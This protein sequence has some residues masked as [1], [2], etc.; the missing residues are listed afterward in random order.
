MNAAFACCCF[1]SLSTIC[2]C[3]FKWLPLKEI[4]Y[5]CCC[6]FFRIVIIMVVRWDTHTEK[7][8]HPSIKLINHSCFIDE[9]KNLINLIRL[10]WL[11]KEKKTHRSQ[12]KYIELSKF[13][14][15]FLPVDWEMWKN[16]W[17]TRLTMHVFVHS[18]SACVCRFAQIY[19]LRGRQIE[20]AK[21]NGKQLIHSS[22]I[23]IIS[24]CLM[25]GFLLEDLRFFCTIFNW[26]FLESSKLN[27]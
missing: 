10:C 9:Q 4:H 22:I 7:K 13:L 11:P 21:K 20:W 6:C 24:L 2:V 18:L 5:Y 14:T 3:V 16:D 27:E 25:L 23:M 15:F 17:G 1:F 8:T 26:Q 19:T 12:L